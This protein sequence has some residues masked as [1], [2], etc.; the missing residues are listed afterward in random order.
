MY[1]LGLF[2]F[3]ENSNEF[4]GKLVAD[5]VDRTGFEAARCP[6]EMLTRLIGQV[7]KQRAVQLKC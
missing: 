7:L 3:L 4:V 2:R 5:A 6:A 1:C